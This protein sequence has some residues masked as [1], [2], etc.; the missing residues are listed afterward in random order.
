M[1]LILKLFQKIFRNLTNSVN[2][3]NRKY[4]KPRIKLTKSVKIALFL[5]RMYLLLLVGLLIY[6]FITLL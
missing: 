3:I 4:A 6:K 5:L 1:Y 2:E